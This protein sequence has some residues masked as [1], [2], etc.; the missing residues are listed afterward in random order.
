MLRRNASAT[1][2][3]SGSLSE[4][5]STCVASSLINAVCFS[6]HLSFCPSDSTADRESA[7]CA[8]GWELISARFRIR[9]PFSAVEKWLGLPPRL[10]SLHSTNDLEQPARW[11]RLLLGESAHCHHPGRLPDHVR[12]EESFHEAVGGQESARTLR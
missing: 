12:S 10:Q 7:I 5:S 4:L 3:H 8:I 1:S 11:R 6:V 2:L 9:T